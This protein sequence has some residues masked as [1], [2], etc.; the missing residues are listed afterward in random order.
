MKMKK[1]LF[2]LLA[3]VVLAGCSSVSNLTPSKLP[4]TNA[5]LYRVETKFATNKRAIVEDTIQAYV[6]SGTERTPLT[7]T[8]LVKD[9]WEGDLNVASSQ[10]KTHFHFEFDYKVNLVPGKLSP[11]QYVSPEYGLDIVDATDLK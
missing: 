10:A 11:G 1:Y 7:H 4:R 5:G 2:L 9:R 8:D 3:P 6:V